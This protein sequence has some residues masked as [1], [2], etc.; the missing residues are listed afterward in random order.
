MA[1]RTKDT[2]T[3]GSHDVN[4]QYLNVAFGLSAANTFSDLEVKLPIVRIGQ[5]SQNR[6]TIIEVLK[7]FANLPGIDNTAAAATQRNVAM[8]FSTVRLGAAEAV[9][10]NPRVLAQFQREVQNSFTAGGTGILAIDNDPQV[11]D[12]TDG[13]GHGVLVAS[14]SIWVAGVTTNQLAASTFRAKILYRFK[15]V[16]LVEYIGLVQSQQ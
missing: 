8:T 6:S 16:S 5:G 1:K 2:L 10:D 3:G 11:W 7:I 14:D 9:I 12:L 4:P 13:D 15:E